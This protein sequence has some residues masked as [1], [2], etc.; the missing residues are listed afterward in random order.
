MLVGVTLLQLV[1][2]YLHLPSP[3][4]SF[5]SEGT[6]KGS[7]G[8]LGPRRG[9]GKEKG[10]LRYPAHRSSPDS[11]WRSPNV[12]HQLAQSKWKGQLYY[13]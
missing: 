13:M 7:G 12:N 6:Y 11:S 4:A 8:I 1:P 2:P 9:R 5:L 10:H 3:G